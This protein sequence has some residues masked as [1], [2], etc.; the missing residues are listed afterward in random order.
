MSVAPVPVATDFAGLARL[1]EA[2]QGNDPKVLREAARQF[3]A[4]FTQMLMKS[5]RAVSFG[6]DLTGEQGG[7]YKDMLDQQMAVHLS[8]G[9]GLGL[10]EV[11]IRQLQ[12]ANGVTDGAT[13]AGAAADIADMAT[14]ALGGRKPPQQLFSALSAPGSRPAD[15]RP[16][17]PEQ[18]V[19]DLL[20]HAQK[21]AGELGVSPRML[22]A[23]AALE[24]GWGRHP[25]RHPDGTPSYNLFGI[26]AGAGWD[27]AR[28]RSMTTEYEGGAALRQREEFRAYPSIEASFEDYVRLLKTQPRYAEALRKGQDEERWARG[29][30]AA[31]YAT[32]PLYADKL[33]ALAQSPALNAVPAASATLSA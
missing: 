13:A 30:Q 31:G 21:A 15:W 2:A 20:P 28:V 11:M 22:I 10:A 26:K 27:G 3:E 25:I 17:T 19:K 1:R 23:Q 32:D 5:M 16:E 6:D 24:T 12:G 14:S 18:F 9:K 7:F 29:L 4:L 8:S 33:S